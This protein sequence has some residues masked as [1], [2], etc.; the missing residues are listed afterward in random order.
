MLGG[1][2]LQQ[3]AVPRPAADNVDEATDNL[4]GPLFT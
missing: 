1:G 4:V 2:P 3:V